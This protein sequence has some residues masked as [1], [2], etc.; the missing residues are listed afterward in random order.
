MGKIHRGLEY[1]GQK[2]TNSNRAERNVLE[3]RDISTEY[4]KSEEL[5]FRHQLQLRNQWKGNQEL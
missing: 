5:F 1:K 4:G 2:G 3:P